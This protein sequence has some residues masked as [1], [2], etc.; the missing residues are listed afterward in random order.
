MD[1][2]LSSPLKTIR[3]CGKMLVINIILMFKG[4]MNELKTEN[5]LKWNM[6]FWPSAFYYF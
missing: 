3:G 1:F 2:P 5:G 6:W 4:K